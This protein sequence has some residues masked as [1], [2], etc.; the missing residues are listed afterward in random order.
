MNDETP[1]PISVVLLAGSSGKPDPM[2]EAAAVACKAL[3]PLPNGMAMLEAVLAAFQASP[4]VGRVVV[5]GDSQ[6]RD[7]ADAHS[8]SFAPQGDS[9]VTNLLAGFAALDWP[10]RCAV[11]TC[12]IPLI[13]P[14]A[15][16]S[17]TGA[18]LGAELDIV[19]PIVSRDTYERKFPGGKRTYATLKDGTFT[20]GNVLLLRSEFVRAQQA[21]IQVVFDARKSPLRLCRILGVGFVIKFLTKRL[22][23]H[24]IED[25]VGRLLHC[26]PQ[27]L[28]FDYA[29]IAFDVDHLEDL[30]TVGK[31]LGSQPT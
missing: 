31:L 16:E 26:T 7:T 11:A 19:Y 2:A 23:I 14:D 12:D 17:L 13:S 18:G 27:A 21:I 29:E 15:I 4:S 9:L 6:L 20:G 3:L 8:V 1:A 25:R 30:E 22:T 28:V 10:P 24:E 5:V